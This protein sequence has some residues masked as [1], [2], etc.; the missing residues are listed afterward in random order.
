MSSST[1]FF[2]MS[3]LGDRG[4]VYAAATIKNGSKTDGIYVGG[5]P[6]FW[7]LKTIHF[8]LKTD[9]DLSVKFVYP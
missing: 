5:I 9:S 1:I 4:F 3:F 8:Q 2:S 6:C 7:S